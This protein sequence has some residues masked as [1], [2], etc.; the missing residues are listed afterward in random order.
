MQSLDSLHQFLLLFTWFPL[1]LILALML[2][3]GRFYQ[4]F[5]GE[6]TFYWFY[7]PIIVLF[8]AFFV[9]LASLD[10]GT[11]DLL[12]NALSIVAGSCLLFSSLLLYLR[13]MNNNED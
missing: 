10:F 11:T 4:K 13:M 6:S 5:S 3:I 8:G 7:V 12:A 9:R 1:A 2:L